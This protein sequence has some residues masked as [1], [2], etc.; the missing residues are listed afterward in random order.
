MKMQ[1]LHTIITENRHEGPGY[2]QLRFRGD[3]PLA[4]LP[5]QFVMIR[6]DWGFHPTL[7]RAFSL[8]RAGAE[9]A[10]LVRDVGEGTHRLTQLQPGDALDVLGPLGNA[11]AL[12]PKG[13][14]PVLVAG[15]VGVAPLAFLAQQLHAAGRS[16]VFVY[17]ARAAADLSLKD[18]LAALGPLHCVTEDGSYGETGL[19]TA[20]LQRLLD[21]GTP[22]AVMACGPHPM[23]RAVTHLAL[24]AN[25]PVQVALEAPMACGLGTCKGCVVTAHD[26]VFH[27][28]CSDGPVFDGE[29][30]FGRA[31]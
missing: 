28:V 11:F 25:A 6:G 30:I 18:E 9:G 3:T 16:F 31:P 10:V 24:A 26:G 1:F 21:D 29:V 2:A 4:G 27:Y 19:V 17:G 8:V 12:P 5:G 13:V 20:P 15:G 7:P 23:L 14:R 22:S